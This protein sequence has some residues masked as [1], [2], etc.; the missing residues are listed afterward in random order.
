MQTPVQLALHIEHNRIHTQ[1]CTAQHIHP[2]NSTAHPP[3]HDIGN[4]TIENNHHTQSTGM[5]EL[6]VI[7]HLEDNSLLWQISNKS[8]QNT[9][10]CILLSSI[11]QKTPTFLEILHS[12][13]WFF[14]SAFFQFYD[15]YEWL[16]SCS[17]SRLLQHYYLTSEHFS[18]KRLRK[19]L[20]LGKILDPYGE[21]SFL[22]SLTIDPEDPNKGDL[23]RSFQL[24]FSG[25]SGRT[26]TF[27]VLSL[28]GGGVRGLYTARILERLC[29]AC[30]TLLDN[31]DLIAGS[32]T[33]ALIGVLLGKGYS[34]QH[35]VDI[36][37]Q[38][39]TRIFHRSIFRHYNPFLSRY[40]GFS[41]ASV[42][43]QVCLFP[44][45]VE[46]TV[47]WRH[48][49][50]RSQPLSPCHCVLLRRHW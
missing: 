21:R 12:M 45:F 35:I 23:K 11:Q 15:K 7:P 46:S 33:G 3:T 34:P 43:H 42:L 44:M 29:E 47:L 41:K 30:P 38:S 5:E 24:R 6:Y 48:E 31:I 19:S 50:E 36:Y 25:H 39:S 1:S 9:N 37:R 8:D 4:N 2:Q 17:L 22:S 49:N 20:T 32:S 10:I 13:L 27:R 18:P 40:R 26:H 16:R 14:S 28:D